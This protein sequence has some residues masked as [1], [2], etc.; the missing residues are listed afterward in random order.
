[1]K[2]TRGTIDSAQ[3]VVVY[4]PEGI[5]KSTFASKFPDPLFI[6]TEG[7]TK[8]LDVARLDPPSS[9]TM[10]L[11]QIK[12]VRDNKPCKTLVVDT[13]DWAERLARDHIIAINK[14]SSIESFGYGKGYTYLAEEFGKMLNLLSDVIDAGI[15]V[16]LTAH[17]MMRKFEQPD[18]MGAYDRWELKL[19]KKTAPMAKEWADMVLFANY[20]TT[21]LTDSKS[22]SKKAVGGERV[23]YTTHHPARDAK[24]RADLPEELPLSY[25][26]IAHLF[27]NPEQLKKEAS[28][29]EERKSEPKS[30]AKPKEEPI[31]ETPPAT[32]AK[33]P[34][35]KALRDL[36]EKDSITDEMI[37]EVIYL[38]GYFPMN[39]P[40]ENLPAEF[41]DGVLIGAWPQVYQ[42]MVE[43]GITVP[44]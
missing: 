37:Q 25:E 21:I 16:V 22:K 27:G 39:T 6:D 32:P 14:V 11:E 13:I 23:M 1:M 42:Y 5:G 44:F 35:P 43:K 28:I 33:D 34:L 2:I 19:E 31:K 26:P 3:K 40:L 29:Q 10:L 20:K 41:I 7:S 18:E 17:A 9:W 15:H 4:G 24:N 36:M 8:H 38:R 12:F 30:E